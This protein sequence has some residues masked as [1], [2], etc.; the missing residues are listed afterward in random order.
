MQKCF[1]QQHLEMSSARHLRQL[2]LVENLVVTICTY[3]EIVD[4]LGGGE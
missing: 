2:C 1:S 3:L 4:L